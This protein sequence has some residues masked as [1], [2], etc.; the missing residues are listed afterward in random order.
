MVS[1]TVRWPFLNICGCLGGSIIFKSGHQSE[2]EQW[3]EHLLC[4]IVATCYPKLL[5][6]INNQVSQSYIQSLLLLRQTTTP[7]PKPK[8]HYTPMPTEHAS[9]RH[10]TY[11]ILSSTLPIHE[12]PIVIS[13]YY[14]LVV[15]P[16]RV[17]SHEFFLVALFGTWRRCRKIKINL[18]CDLCCGNTAESVSLVLMQ[19]ESWHGSL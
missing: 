14:Y 4:Y 18:F 5:H 3:V 1:V 11:S 17:S 15:T 16:D 9:D 19:I 6:H 13:S 12:Y 2:A 8:D 10:L 7:F